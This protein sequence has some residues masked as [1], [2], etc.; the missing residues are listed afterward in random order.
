M[1]TV[2]S[3][4]KIPWKG[5]KPD[6][7]LRGKPLVYSAAA[8]DRYY[9]QLKT[10]I[11]KMTV[12]THRELVSLL[13]QPD[14]KDYFAMDASVSSQ[15]RI[16][17]NALR[18]RFDDLFG[19]KSKDI[20]MSVSGAA[21][22]TS[23]ASLKLSI[24]DLAQGVTLKTDIFSTDLNEIFTAIVAENV[25][26]IR[27]ISSEYMTQIQGAVMRSITTGNGLADL[28]PF[29]RN[30]EGVTLRRAR[31][32]ANDQTRKAF[33][34][35]NAARMEKLDIDK[36]EWLHSAGGQTPRKLHVEMSG[37]VY[38]LKDPPVIDEKTGQRGLPGQ[39]INCRC[40]MV[41]VISF[42]EDSE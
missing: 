3:I 42:D 39:L 22:K 8:A 28:V 20:A 26:L 29:L 23:A 17:T 14:A 1:A 31:L 12:T 33:T 11:L 36:F 7:V 4:R 21:D 24:K 30:Y 34:N 13:K 40:R 37:N 18:D 38:S 10:L 25:S 6:S 2:K 32:I 9:D 15:A 35:V 27:S 5:K 41:P 16:L 19:V